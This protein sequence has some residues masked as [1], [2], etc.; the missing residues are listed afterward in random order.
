MAE[1]LTALQWLH[2]IVA[3]FRW[4]PNIDDEIARRARGLNEAN[5]AG[6]IVQRGREGCAGCRYYV[7]THCACHAQPPV[8]Q[9]GNNHP[10]PSVQPND[11]CGAFSSVSGAEA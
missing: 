3:R 7:A 5:R 9:R 6:A 4:H 2:V 11:W 8:Q 10:W 1:F